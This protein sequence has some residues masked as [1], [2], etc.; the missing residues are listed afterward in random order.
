[1][2]FASPSVEYG[3]QK[4]KIGLTA[5]FVLPSTSGAACG[6]WDP[7]FWFQLAEFVGP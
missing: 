4:E 5:L 7:R 3:P 2:F 1:L 6:F